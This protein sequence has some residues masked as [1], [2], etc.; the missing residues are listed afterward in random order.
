MPGVPNGLALDARYLAAWGMVT[1]CER[2]YS[3]GSHP[4]AIRLLAYLNRAHM[5]SYQATLADPSLGLDLSRTRA[6][7]YKYGFGLD[8][9]QE[10]TKNVG[11]FCRVGWSDGRNEAWMFADVD[12]TATAGVS[13]KGE[14]WH[15]PGD[16]LGLGGGVNAVSDIHRAYF[17]AGGLGILAGDGAL[18]YGWEKLLESYYDVQISKHVHAAVDYQFVSD[19]AYNRARGPVHILGLRLHADF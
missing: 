3:V 1:E 17:S 8:V 6:Y 16:T 5:G 18:S 15:R 4:G 12:R 2:R 19:P 11:V 9:G 7:R 10:L 13:V 14:A